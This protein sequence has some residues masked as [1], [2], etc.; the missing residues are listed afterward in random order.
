MAGG[1]WHAALPMEAARLWTAT[2]FFHGS[3]VSFHVTAASHNSCH[4]EPIEY[5]GIFGTALK[6]AA[7]GEVAVTSREVPFRHLASPQL[8]RYQSAALQ[9][10][11]RRRLESPQG[12]S[13]SE[14]RRL[15]FLCHRCKFASQLVGASPVAVRQACSGPHP[16][17]LR[18]GVAV[19][20]GLPFPTFSGS[21]PPRLGWPGFGTH[22]YTSRHHASICQ[23]S[24]PVTSRLAG[25]LAKPSWFDGSF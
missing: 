10:Y 6:S 21:P 14:L 17:Q 24:M 19:G 12:L 16:S 15:Q 3:S 18:R 25:R 9:S 5:P 13:Q 7:T 11:S 8:D 23:A 1:A 20:V 2:G 4:G 22:R